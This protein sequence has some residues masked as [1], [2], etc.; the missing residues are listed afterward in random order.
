MSKARPLCR[1][2]GTLPSRRPLI[3]GATGSDETIKDWLG[4]R[5]LVR[6]DRDGNRGHGAALA[7]KGS[8]VAVNSNIDLTSGTI[9]I[10]ATGSGGN[11]VVGGNLSTTG[12]VQAFSDALEYTSGG[13]ISL[14]SDTGSVV[15]NSTGVIN[16]A[17]NAGGG[18]AGS[19]TITAPGGTFVH[20]GSL[21]GQ[22]G[23]GGQGGSFTLDVATQDVSSTL[24]S[25]T[26]QNNTGSDLTPLETLLNTGGFTQSQSIRVQ[27]G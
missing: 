14:K 13:Q 26:S 7:L 3:V 18:N 17:A 5:G 16:V 20:N 27:S 11:V 15:L 23:A 8:S 10:E 21:L 1:H 25:G 22:A 9:D 12:T 24:D 4:H 19:V 2:R 6:F